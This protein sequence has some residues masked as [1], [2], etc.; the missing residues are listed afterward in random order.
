MERDL[1]AAHASILGFRSGAVAGLVVITPACGFVGTS[2]AIL[3][4]VLAAVVPDIFWRCTSK[5]SL[6]NDDAS[7]IASGVH[8]VGGNSWRQIMTGFLADKAVNANPR[9][10]SDC[11]GRPPR[12]RGNVAVTPGNRT[13]GLVGTQLPGDRPR[14]RCVFYRGNRGDC[15]T[16]LEAVNRTASEH[17]EVEDA[18]LDISEH[19]E[20][21]YII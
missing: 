5:P 9:Y 7:R 17:P 16:L 20:E 6:V 14:H 15:A 8:A 18:G 4:G 2:G 11:R 21:G 12:K 3:I 1:A 10:S 13:G 19:G